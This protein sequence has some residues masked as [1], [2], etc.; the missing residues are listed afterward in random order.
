[1]A[2]EAASRAGDERAA[3]GAAVAAPPSN[4]GREQLF[5]FMID[6]F[7]QKTEEAGSYH[8]FV[9]CYSR[10]YR[11]QPE[12]TK[13]VYNQFICHL[14]TSVREEIQ[15]LK[16]EGN[17]SVL[18]GSLD[19]LV[20]GAKQREMPTW[21]PSGIPEEDA[22]SAVVPYLLKQRRFLQKAL[23]EKEEASEKLAQTVLAGRNRI[24][25]LQEEIKKRKEEWQAVA[26]K[27]REIVNTLDEL[28]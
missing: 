20:E 15:E 24:A 22:R 5:D 4:P 11:A 21:R 23:K 3:A 19:D 2:T 6:L 8:R 10:L 9:K 26:Q 25:D 27:S 7:L 12:L 14:Q 17:L 1:M 13:C 16:E 28:Q 18:F